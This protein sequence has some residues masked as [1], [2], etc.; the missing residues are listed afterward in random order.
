[1]AFRYVALAAAFV[2]LADPSDTENQPFW[3]GQPDAPTFERAVDTRLDRARDLHARLVGV[4]GKR[5]VANTLE[6]YDRLMRELDRAGSATRLIQEVHPDSTLRQAGERG[7]SKGPAL[8][9]E[10]PP[11]QRGVA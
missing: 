7:E 5:T 6:P 11:D 8:S 9:K 10:L 4:K 1:M 2:A 3:T